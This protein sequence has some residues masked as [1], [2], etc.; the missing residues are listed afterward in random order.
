MLQLEIVKVCETTLTKRLVEFEN[1]ES[2]S[3][4]I[5]EL[6][7]MA[8]EHEKNDPI[9]IP[10]GE[11]SKSTSKDLLCEHKAK[12]VPYFALGLCEAC[13]KD[14][15]HFFLMQTFTYCEYSLLLP[16]TKI[17]TIAV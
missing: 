15:S 14:V 5:E 4:T 10:N 16:F 2:G 1:T 3:L 11:L 9:K 8:K 17:L 6:Y 13:Y 12:G 7:T